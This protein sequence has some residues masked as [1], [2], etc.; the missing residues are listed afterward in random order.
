[1]LLTQEEAYGMGPALVDAHGNRTELDAESY[2]VVKT[3]LRVINGGKAKEDADRALTTGQVAE[4]LGVS[5]R[6]VARMVDSGDLSCVGVSEGGHRRVLLSDA[7]AYK[8]ASAKRTRLA[9]E[10]L[11]DQAT[12]GGLY[13][14]DVEDYLSQFD[15]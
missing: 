14:M 13:D 15:R 12:A 5:S 6:T 8:Q 7:L 11:R 9:L 2:K 1:M 4:L 3:V 10:E